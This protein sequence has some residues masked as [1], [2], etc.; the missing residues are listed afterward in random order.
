MNKSYRPYDPDQQLLL[1]A[2]LREWLPD[3]HL[4][5]FISDVVD[6]LE[7]SE[8]TARYERESRGGPPYHPRMMVK[9]LVYGYCVGV[10]SSRRIARRLHEDIA[11]RVLAANNTPDFRTISDFRK[12]NLEALSELFVQVLALCQQAGLVKLGLV[13][14]DGTKVRAN[15]SK[16]RA[17]SYGRMKEKEAQLSAEV[18]ELLRRA[19]EVDG[20]EDRRYGADK[21]GD[22]LPQEL[23]F[24]EG[25]LEKIREAMAELEAEAEA[26]ADQAEAE[27]SAHSRGPDDK[28][29]RNFTDAESR[30]MP[31]PGGRDFVQAYNCQAVVDQEHQVIVAARATNQTSDKQQAVTMMEETIANTGAVPKEVSADAGYYSAQ[32]VAELQALRVE[33]FIAPEKTRHGRPIPQAPRGRIPGHLSPRDRMRR[34]LQTRRGRQRYALRMQTVEPVFGQIKQGRGFRQFLLRGIEKVCGEWSLICTGHN[35]LKLFRCGVDLFGRAPLNR[36]AHRITD[37]T[38]SVNTVLSGKRPRS[39]WLRLAPM[40]VEA[41][42]P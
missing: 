9:V 15:A 22:E 25:R 11:F 5:Y 16:H 13:A 37:L 36:S 12:D 30:I 34:K 32:A 2:A 14:L 38:E 40:V 17:M 19:Q 3:D 8:I 20:E 18:D 24:R 1:P 31:A 7:L 23:S 6:Q 39:E 28:A 26:A 10:A 21:R 33:P 4:A 41:C 29:Q 35:L 42:S 27:G